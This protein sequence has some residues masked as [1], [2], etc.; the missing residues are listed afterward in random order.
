MAESGIR[1]NEVPS[2]PPETAR[3]APQSGWRK[4]ITAPLHMLT[5]ILTP[6]YQSTFASTQAPAPAEKPSAWGRFTSFVGGIKDSVVNTFTGAAE[7]VKEKGLLGAASQW[8]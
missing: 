2:G 5:G 4:A 8:A 1:S 6:R 7:T 3:I